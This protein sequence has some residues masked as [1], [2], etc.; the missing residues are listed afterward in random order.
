MSVPPTPH[1]AS[2]IAL[3]KAAFRQVDTSQTGVISKTDFAALLQRLDKNRWTGDAIEGLMHVVDQNGDDQI[4]Y[5]EFLDWCMEGAN[6]VKEF[7]SL[8]RLANC[9]MVTDDLRKEALA[10]LCHRGR[11]ALFPEM[12]AA[13]RSDEELCTEVMG[14]WDVPLKYGADSIRSN[15]TVVMALLD[16]SCRHFRYASQ[17]LRDDEEVVLQA[18]QTH[19]MYPWCMEDIFEHVTEK[20]TGDLVIM[21]VAVKIQPVAFQYATPALQAEKELI[22]TAVKSPKCST[23][24]DALGKDFSE[25]FPREKFAGDKDV[26]SVIVKKMPLL[27]KQASP[28]LRG[29]K[30]LVLAAVERDGDALEYASDELRADREI[31]IS[32]LR[33]SHP[34]RDLL[35]FAADHLRKDDELLEL[36][37]AAREHGGTEVAA[38]R[39]L[40]G[41][42]I[43]PDMGRTG[44]LLAALEEFARPDSP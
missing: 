16:K 28:E 36:Q 21:Q 37:A 34:G 31:V 1:A 18:I 4:Q 39:T 11:S 24:S 30:E 2:H 8:A 33:H 35:Q 40:S 41:S 15:K 44:K 14:S 27:L 42:V 25:W 17:D 5:E 12:S 26:M 22:L 32:A 38:H 23:Y 43:S 10:F 6:E 29:D 19:L 7:L 20:T 13:L 3:I 9:T